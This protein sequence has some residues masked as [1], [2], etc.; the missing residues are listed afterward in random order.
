ML[1][2]MQFFDRHFY[3]TSIMPE[4]FSEVLM[5]FF[6]TLHLMQIIKDPVLSIILHVPLNNRSLAPVQSK[7]TEA[8]EA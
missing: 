4:E 5:C 2:I 1:S 3:F 8:R 6:L 7:T